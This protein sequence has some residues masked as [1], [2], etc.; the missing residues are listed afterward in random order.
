MLYYKL[1]RDLLC[2]DVDSIITEINGGKLHIFPES[3]NVFSRESIVLMDILNTEAG[4]EMGTTSA[5]FL[6]ELIK[7]ANGAFNRE[8]L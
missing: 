2:F 5:D 1:L 3:W 8:A 4:G 6:A 7:S